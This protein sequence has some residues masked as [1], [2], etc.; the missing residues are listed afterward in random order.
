MEIRQLNNELGNID[1]YLLDQ[2]LKGNVSKNA[3]ILD[4]G[5]G[6]GRNLVYFLNNGYD[7]YGIDANEDAIRMLHFILGSKYPEVDKGRFSVGQIQN[8]PYQDNTFD[9]VICSAVLHFADSQDDWLRMMQQLIRVMRVNGILFIRA[10]SDFGLTGHQEL[11]DGQYQLPDGS[12]RFLLNKTI[13]DSTMNELSLEPIEPYKTVIV[14][15]QR[16]MTTLVMR[17]TS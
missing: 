13:L 14:H 8:L 3:K 10:A 4:A 1:L 16:C 9:Y 7:V 12:V 17:K 11:K 5:C 15:G 6:E 2:I